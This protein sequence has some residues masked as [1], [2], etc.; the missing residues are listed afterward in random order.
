MIDLIAGLV[1]CVLGIAAVLLL[2]LCVVASWA[3]AEFE[4]T[5]INKE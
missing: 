5:T 2:M 1:L 3:D 4:L